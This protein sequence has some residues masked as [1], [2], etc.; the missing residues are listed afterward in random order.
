[1]VITTLKKERVFVKALPEK[2]RLLVSDRYDAD[3]SVR[4]LL[5]RI[6][7]RIKYTKKNPFQA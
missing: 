2:L 5:G 1:M 4:L 3:A 6:Q 7:L